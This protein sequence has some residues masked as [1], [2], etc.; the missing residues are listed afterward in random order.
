[1]TFN[2]EARSFWREVEA[3]KRRRRRAET[4]QDLVPTTSYGSWA[5]VLQGT[6]FDPAHVVADAVR[7]R[8]GDYD[9]KGLVEAYAAAVNEALPEGV[10][11]AGREFYGPYP[12]DEAKAEAIR[13]AVASVDLTPLM[14]RFERSDV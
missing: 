13:P 3:G 1:M 11:L 14:E 4:M 9:M 12:V 10:T 6:T 5:A 7:G 8:A 2:R